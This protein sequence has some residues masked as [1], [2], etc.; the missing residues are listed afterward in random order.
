MSNVFIVTVKYR[1]DRNNHSDVNDI[2]YETPAE[3][4]HAAWETYDQYLD[5]LVEYWDKRGDEDKTNRYTKFIKEIKD[6]KIKAEVD[7]AYAKNDGRC[8]TYFA[9]VADGHLVVAVKQL[10]EGA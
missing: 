5:S 2:Y 1:D 10:K 6:L 8:H 3:A 7:E 4:N 9:N